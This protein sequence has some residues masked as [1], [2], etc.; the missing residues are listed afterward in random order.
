[1]VNRIADGRE[2][3]ASP[4]HDSRFAIHD[5]PKRLIAVQV[6]LAASVAPWYSAYGLHID[7]RSAA[8]LPVA[9]V[10]L[11]AAW[12][13][14][15]R[16]YSAHPHKSIYADVLLATL[17]LLLV[18]NIAS[19]AQY[20]AIALRR[21]LI[22]DWL[23][24]ADASLGIDVAALATWTRS[25]PAVSL[26]LS[27][28]YASLIA[29][30]LM[31]LVIVGLRDRDR[32]RL[33]EYVFHFNFCLIVTIVTL[34]IFPAECPY[35]HL[36]FTP[37]ID[38]ARVIA[39]I[40][41]LRAGTFRTI[42]FGNL[43]GLVS[44]PSFHAAGAIMVTWAFRRHRVLCPVLIVLNT[45]LIAATFLSGVHYFVDIVGAFVLFAASVAAF[46]LVNREPAAAPSEVPTGAWTPLRWPRAART[47]SD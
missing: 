12:W 40:T 36:G 11:V 30:F 37:T 1:M 29:Q 2:Q 3:F 26:V 42:D 23:T 15:R 39:H 6:C 22:D 46:R 45:G 14:C 24:R 17:V 41:A 35:T 34:A 28:C 5:L 27:A 38:Q 47:S 31:P 8:L 21:P 9:H 33:W 7:W 25:H 43:D 32:T 4:I 16:R 18:T 13:Y 20:L 19:P 44:M 10:A